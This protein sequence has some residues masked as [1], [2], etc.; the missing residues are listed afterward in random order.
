MELSPDNTI[1]WQWGPVKLN[2]TILYTLIVMAILVIGSWLSTR[3]L[4]DQTK[5]TRRQ[6]C[7][8]PW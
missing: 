8:K 7:S 6:T 2:A 5:L 3:Q 1:F 4:S